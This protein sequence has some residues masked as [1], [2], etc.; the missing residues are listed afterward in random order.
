MTS[1]NIKNA[2]GAAATAGAVVA[3][4]IAFG[5]GVAQAQPSHDW[6]GVAECESSGNWAANT[7]NG[8]YGGLQF[9]QSTWEGFG[10]SGNPANASKAEQ[11]R[12]AENVLAGQ[13]VGAWPVCGQYLTSGTTPGADA[14]AE[15]AAAPAPEV[16]PAPAAAPPAPADVQSYI[17]K[18]G[19]TL[20]GI[21]L[22]EQVSLQDLVAQVVNPD[23]IY[24]GDALALGSSQAPAPAAPEAP[25]APAPADP[26]AAATQAV[27]DIVQPVVGT[28]TSNFGSRWGTQHGGIDVAAPIGTPV[29]ATEGGEV[30]SAGP[31]DGFGQWVRILHPSGATSVYGHINTFL[32]NVGETVSAGQQIATVG[33]LGQS[34]GPHLHF[35][36]HD[37]AGIKLDPA[38]W[39]ADN[40]VV[41]SWLG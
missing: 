8:F 15:Q 40:G 38:A 16:A 27:Q 34:T 29:L 19:D 7:G 10:G 9:K 30:I 25:A 20:S 3:L 14:P 13:G 39:L 18:L 28:L 5:G 33:N 2:L 4:P 37:A 36:V 32:V 26:V 35:E 12:V 21:A 23:L 31:A 6:S 11:I 1:I 41:A 17:V 24:P 22:T